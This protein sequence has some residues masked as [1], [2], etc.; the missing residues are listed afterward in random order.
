MDIPI[1]QVANSGYVCRCGAYMYANIYQD[2]TFV[3]CP[4]CGESFELEGGAEE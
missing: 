2:K 3:I 4:L 1:K